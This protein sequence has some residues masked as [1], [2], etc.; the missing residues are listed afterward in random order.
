MA[1]LDNYEREAAEDD[2]GQKLWDKGKSEAK[3][4]AKKPLKKAAKKAKNAIMEKTGVIGIKKA[5]GR[6]MQAALKAMAHAGKAAAT[7]ALSFLVSNPVGWVISAVLIIGG[8]A[9][10]EKI[11]YDSN[12]IIE[13]ETTT[14]LT[15]NEGLT[16]DGVAI[17]M[18]DC[19]DV[20]TDSTLAEVNVDAVT[21]M[22]AKMIYAVFHKY[23]LSDECIA[24]MLGNLFAESGIDT[25]SVEGIY[26]EPY[27]LG[28]K[29][30]A[31]LA[32]LSAH[33]TGHIWPGYEDKGYHIRKDGYR[34]SDGNLY[35]GLGFPQW[36]GPAAE[37]LLNFSK[38][39]G[40][41]WWACDFQTAYMLS[42]AHY[43]PGF[44][45]QWKENMQTDLFEA[46]RY[47]AHNYEGNDSMAVDIRQEAAQMWYDKIAGWEVDEAY[48]NSIF[49][50]SES[51]GAVA[52]DTAVGESA[53]NCAGTGG[54]IGPYD[55]SSIASAAASYAY[56][57]K[58]EG[59]GNN[60]TPLYIQVHDNVFPGDTIYQS[61]DRS[62]ACAIRW[63]GSDD[64]FP[65]GD[66]TGQYNYLKSSPKW[67]SVGMAST[68][69]MDKLMPGDVFATN[70]HVLLYVGHDAV[71]AA[72]GENAPADADSVSGSFGE[73]SPGCGNDATRIIG[74]GGVDGKGR[75]YEVFRCV[76]PD[77]S[78]TYKNAG[79]SAVMQ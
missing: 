41:D 40:R 23:G 48:A 34:G 68:L 31:A 33:V 57:T 28:A 30:Q 38:S 27:Q 7:S 20:K 11:E 66:S 63:S 55:N 26:D 73:R 8:I 54:E 65:S 76:D 1:D 62:I 53:S 71:V 60:G 79:A 13:T 49:K 42:D 46:E 24:G 77:E 18:G 44:F 25:T 21:E 45:A 5:A 74:R 10:F 17:L 78:E 22:N 9:I 59:K 29:K 58:D 16:E 4:Q 47:F 67:E 2:L 51:M 6:G 3:R 61:C 37:A 69:S 15:D 50:L 35:C 64:E 36:T 56:A 12:E 75:A 14:D 43:R 70:G 52:G 32:D 72:H 39:T 19:P